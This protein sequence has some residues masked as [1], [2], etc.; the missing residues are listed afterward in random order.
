MKCPIA[1]EGGKSKPARLEH[2]DAGAGAGISRVVDVAP[3]VVAGWRGGTGNAGNAGRVVRE[4]LS[5]S[6]PVSSRPRTSH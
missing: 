6:R 5:P 1:G 4:I 3:D 2:G